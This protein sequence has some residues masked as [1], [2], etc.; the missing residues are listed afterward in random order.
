MLRGMD[1]PGGP[2]TLGRLLGSVWASITACWGIL[3][4]PGVSVGVSEPPLGLFRRSGRAFGTFLK[5][6]KTFGFYIVFDR[7]G[8]FGRCLGSPRASCGWVSVGPPA[9]SGGSLGTHWEAMCSLR[10]ALERPPR[11]I[12]TLGA[13]P[14]GRSGIPWAPSGVL[15]ASLG[16]LRALLGGSWGNPRE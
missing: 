9:C 13:S 15:G 7:C 12:W 6:L 11:E 8:I 2:R 14:G 3:G 16:V 10:D 5:T 1:V 4:N